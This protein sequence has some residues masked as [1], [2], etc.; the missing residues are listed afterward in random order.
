MPLTVG[1]STAEPPVEAAP[2]RFLFDLASPECWLVAERILTVMPVACEWVPVHAAPPAFRCAAEVD[3]L[4]EDVARRAAQLGLQ[5]V[6][7]PAD[8]PFDSA[9]AMR[10]ATFAKGTGRTVAFAQAAFRQAW[11]GGRSLAEPES[12]LIAAAA[13]ELHPAAVLKGAA[14]RSTA[15]ALAC[16]SEGVERVPA[17]RLP[18]GEVLEGEDAPERAARALT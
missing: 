3:A 11:C 18:G 8:V 9:F 1:S 7:F 17:I 14:L 16:A 5:A 10:A 13:C 15:T 6:R 2:A 4:R 12:V